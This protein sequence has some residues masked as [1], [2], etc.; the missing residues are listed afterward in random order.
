MFS[1]PGT[2][3]NRFM[4]IGNGRALRLLN[5]GRL[6]TMFYN[7]LS[8]VLMTLMAEVSSRVCLP[9]T[10]N[11]YS[12]LSTNPLPMIQADI[13][14]DCMRLSVISVQI[15]LL[16]FKQGMRLSFYNLI[17]LSQLCIAFSVWDSAR[18]KILI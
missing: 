14:I 16:T 7:Q 8:L 13:V 1:I 2:S 18:F 5:N 12:N 9:D 15:V 17:D 3:S 6:I 11:L 4:S 10:S